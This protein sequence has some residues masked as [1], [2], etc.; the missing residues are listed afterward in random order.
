MS[1][2]VTFLGDIADWFD[3]TL[4]SVVHVRDRVVAFADDHTFGLAHRWNPVSRVVLA[5]NNLGVHMV[6]GFV[7]TLRLGNGVRQGGWRGYGEDAL[8]LLNVFDG[9]GRMIGQVGRVFK[10]AVQA[11]GTALCRMVATY[12]ALERTGHRFFFSL[13][14]LVQGTGRTLDQINAAG[15][16]SLRVFEDLLAILRRVGVP[17][18]E[19]RF[20]RSGPG[21]DVLTGWAGVNRRGVF[22]IGITYERGGGV[23]AAHALEVAFHR[24]HGL[25]FMD[26]SGRA[27][28][29]VAEFL[30]TYRGARL[31]T[32]RPVVFIPNSALVSRATPASGLSH[33]AS[34][35]DNG[36]SLLTNLIVQVLPVFT[37]A[38]P[39]PDEAAGG[40]TSGL[41][42]GL[43][44]PPRTAAHRR[45]RTYTV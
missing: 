42:G 17:L 25:V 40:S 27:Y 45:S 8:R 34:G 15:G 39:L 16:T 22:V 13:A 21:W 4:T 35:A 33:L 41:T 30:A 38:G 9:A 29:G 1:T 14:D 43:T 44:G 36:G 37:D 2:N 24:V 28:H 7:D 11:P 32:T 26:T 6:R 5:A 19:F 18:Q 10:V 20:T 12:S 31:S 23:C 3:R